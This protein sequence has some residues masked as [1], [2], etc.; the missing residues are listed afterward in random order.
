MAYGLIL[1]VAAVLLAIRF[2]LDQEAAPALR[3]LLAAVVAGTFVVPASTPAL[4][5]SITLV[6]LT[7]CLFIL[8]RG[9]ARQTM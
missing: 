8:L 3:V 9:I 5:I 6:R 7:V 2:A 1:A 4:G